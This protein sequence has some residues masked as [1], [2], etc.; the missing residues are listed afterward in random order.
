[1]MRPILQRVVL[2]GIAAATAA[3]TFAVVVVGSAAGGLQPPR[4]AVE[5]VVVL[6]SPAAAFAADRRAA[7]RRIAAEQS[8]FVTAL[9]RAVPAASVRWRYGLVANGLAVVAPRG[10][11]GRIRELPGVSAVDLPVRYRL[12]RAAGPRD[13]G[14]PTLWGGGLE[15]AGQGI[16]IGII[17]DGLD[18]SHPYFSPAGYEMPPGFPKGQTEYTTAK[19]IV[20]RSFPP[21]S[22]AWK[23]AL[24]PFDPENS[25]HATHVAGIAAGNAQT[26]A[27][28]GQV[29][30]GVAP[31]AYIGNYKALTVPT[32]SGVGLDGNA[33]EIVAAIEAAVRDGMDVINL[34]IGEPEIEPSR[35]RVALA[36]DAA[37]AA[38]VVPV[39]AAGND[40]ASFGRGSVTSPGSSPAAITV[41]ATTESGG[42]G[43]PEMASFSSAGPTALSLRLKPDVSAPGSGILSAAPRGEWRT[44]SGT[45]MAAPHVAGGAALLLQRHPEWSVE[46]VKAALVGTARA[47]TLPDAGEAPPTRA[48]SGS[49]DLAAAVNPLV[50]ATPTGVSFGPVRSGLVTSRTIALADAG[51]GA[52][53]WNVA[54]VT[55]TSAGSAAVTAP[56]LVTV[57]GALELTLSTAGGAAEEIGG[58]VRLERGG[59][60]RRIPFWARVTVPML[61]LESP[62]RLASAGVY[63]GNTRGR[64]S[65]VQRYLYPDLPIG[66]QSSILRGPEQ[67][68]RFRLPRAAANFGV[69]VVERARTTTVEPRIVAADDEWRLMGY[70]ALPLNINPYLAGFDSPT[71][72]AGVLN[73]LPREYDIVFDSPTA[74]GAGPFAFRLWVDDVSPPSLKFVSRTVPRD[75]PIE[76]R[77]A[78]SGSGADPDSIVVTLDGAPRTARLSGAVLRIPTLGLSPGKHRLR[79]QISDRQET[80]NNE[81]VA[82][83]LPNTRIVATTITILPRTR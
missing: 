30:S 55:A 77:V 53:E 13:I 49:I 17:D 21:P 34:S 54:I 14:A 37:A 11:L 16:K 56:P 72:I 10:S 52:G 12:Q 59:I 15:T 78:D 60:L 71:P 25:D 64:P 75:A 28:G 2:S 73:P 66:N 19:V 44:L 51:G 42:S 9:G 39:V 26:K 38:G 82:A 22:P 23:N 24:K 68:F 4:E 79:V 20:A 69:A 32:D 43:S 40:F 27:S 33:P 1:M 7:L 36:L 70:A 57:P 80:R 8:R 48:G 67:V 31:R 46:Q 81:N 18:Q 58:V 76:L 62:R 83:I 35:D 47:A 29:I 5:V 3:L 61:S 41:G 74:A 50:L 45:S 65:R 6:R 63:R